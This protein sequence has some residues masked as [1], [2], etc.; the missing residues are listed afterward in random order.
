MTI[1]KVCSLPEGTHN[2][3]PFKDGVIFNDTRSD[4]VRYVAQ[5]EGSKIFKV[6]SYKNEDLKFNGVDDSQIA[7]QSFGRGLCIISENIVAA[8]SSP[9]TVTLYD[10]RA[11]EKI[12]AVNLTMDIRNAIHG[13]EV[14]AN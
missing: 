1:T 6:P 7:R 3:M 9:S 13:L 10:I 11:G 14:W 8:G 4:V 2:A 5:G 12:S